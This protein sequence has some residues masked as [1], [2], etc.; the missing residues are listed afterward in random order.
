MA[1]MSINLSKK[2]KKERNYIEYLREQG[3]LPKKYEYKTLK[4]L[5][6][7]VAKNGNN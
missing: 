5:L 4:Y 2:S 7:E 3:I 6:R 1:Q